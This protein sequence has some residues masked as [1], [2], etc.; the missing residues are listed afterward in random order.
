MVAGSVVRSRARRA[1]WSFW[2]LL[3]LGV[4]AAGSLGSGLAAPPSPLTGLWVAGSGVLLIASV[5]LVARIVV[6]YDRGIRRSGPPATRHPG[7]DKQR[8]HDDR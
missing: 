8:E 5:T 7:N 6:A 2:I 3:V 4:L 1:V